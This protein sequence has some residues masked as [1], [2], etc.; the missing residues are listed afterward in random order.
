M[1]YTSKS[2]NRGL[3]LLDHSK[4]KAGSLTID[5]VRAI[6]DISGQYSEQIGKAKIA[7]VVESDMDY[8]MT[9]MWETLVDINTDWFASDKL[10][11][12]RDEAMVWLKGVNNQ[13]V[14]G[15]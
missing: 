2:F 13:G 12:N 7:I 1:K 4:L 8:G 5:T 15:C 6:A 9:R 3:L 14:S 10:F 11:R